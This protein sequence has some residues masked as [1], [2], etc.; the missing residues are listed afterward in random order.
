MTTQYSSPPE[1][2]AP[3]PSP[4]TLLQQD[5]PRTSYPLEAQTSQNWRTQ[6]VQ[7]QTGPRGR[8]SKS[9][10]FLDDATPVEGARGDFGGDEKDPH[11]LTLSPKHVIRASVVDNMLMSLDEFSNPLPSTVTSRIPPNSNLRYNFVIGRRHANT[12]SSDASSDNESRTDELSFSQ[13]PH[14][15]RRSNSNSHPYFPR[16]LQTVPSLY[17]EEEP[18][19]R[20]RIFD[21]QRAFAP[22]HNK[23]GRRSGKS[24]GSSSVDLGHSLSGCMLGSAGSRR[25]RSFD[26]GANGHKFPIFEQVTNPKTTYELA[27]QA[28]AA[29]TP[30]VHAGPNRS[31]SPARHSATAP[32]SPIYDVASMSR[33][34]SIKS[35]KVQYARKGR[36]GTTGAV[37]P[38][39]RDELCDLHDNLENL[40]PMPTYFPPQPQSMAMASRKSSLAP[41]DPA[42]TS[43]ERPGFFRRVFG[44][45][46]AGATSPQA[47]ESE[48]GGSREIMTKSPREE[49]FCAATISSAKPHKQLSRD[50]HSASTTAPKEQ[51]IVAKKSSTFFRRRKK[52]M[53]GLMPA[54][55]PL[56]LSSVK[57]ETAQPSPVSS[58]R[59]VMDPYL[60]DGPPQSSQAESRDQSPQ[61]FRIANTSFSQP[62]DASSDH[63]DRMQGSPSQSEQT[64][65]SSPL[66]ESRNH[67]KIKVPYQ[68]L[69][70]STFLAD[71]SGTEEPTAG[72]SHNAPDRSFHGRSPTSP[73][74][75]SHGP[76][77]EGSLAARFPFTSTSSSRVPTPSSGART[78]HSPSSPIMPE[79]AA[80]SRTTRPSQLTLKPGASNNSGRASSS[81]DHTASAVR[82]SPLPSGSDISIHKSAPNTPLTSYAQVQSP[83]INITASPQAMNANTSSEEDRDQALKIFENRDENLD[84]GEVSAWLGDA[85]DARER[86]RAAYMKL[87]EWKNV[88]ILS[89]LRGLC[90]RIALKGETQQVDRMLEAFSK[91]WCECN[92]NHGFKSSGKMVFRRSILSTDH[93]R[94]RPYHLLFRSASEYRLAPCRH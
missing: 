43:K 59:Q 72:S 61:G 64:I 45:K 89:A 94:C 7:P 40:P 18:Q 58:L 42:P 78:P 93:I 81:K 82:D 76:V 79:P 92:S 33:K 51:Q 41:V 9:E 77:S 35:S 67:L 69:Q 39:N 50:H 56:S 88:D 28:E 57:T 73:R 2:P 60:T 53:P 25:S 26:F 12:F 83:T 38:K 19:A 66:P 90:A 54:P 15:G 4:N 10:T 49:S 52:S 24:S 17:E 13:S 70:D 46:Y 22:Y 65:L 34:N 11:D 55:L 8:P 5:N 91:R 63:E 30:I 84:S 44:S 31:R 29:P 74:S 27:D 47:A 75:T 71:S 85:G 48:N 87:F 6:G 14:R 21:S 20:T 32:L 23:N 80:V 16:S 68:D 3:V 37:G 86:V 1:R 36:A 62:N